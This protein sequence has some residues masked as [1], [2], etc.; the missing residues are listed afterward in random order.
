MVALT[1]C[2]WNMRQNPDAWVRLRQIGEERGVQVALLQEAVP[3]PTEGWQTH[4]VWDEV[5]AWRV[6]AH[7]DVR[8]AFASAI[9]VVDPGVG[10]SPVTPQPLNQVAYTDF[11]ISHPG[12]FAV[13]DLTL[14]TGESI[15]AISLYGIWDRDDRDLYAEAT[16][17]R[18]ISDLTSVLQNRVNTPIVLAGDLNVYRDWHHATRGSEWASRYDTIFNRL[19]AYDLPLLGPLGEAPLPGCPCSRAQCDHV[20]TYAH[21][22]NPNNV[23][24]QLDYVFASPALR[25]V[26][27]VVLEDDHAWKYSDHLP[28]LATFEVA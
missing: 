2:S 23:P 13:A 26:E 21:N 20:R 28:V 3:P 5:E 17:H 18:A 15:T 19:A 24:Y 1:V 12:Q 11:P 14:P 9:A 16:L 8:R 10:M 25:L 7:S 4:P 22:M 6:T 27:C